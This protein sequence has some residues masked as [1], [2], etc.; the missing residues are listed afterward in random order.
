[1]GRMKTLSMDLDEMSEMHL[2]KSEIEEYLK[3]EYKLSNIT[4]KKL[5]TSYNYNHN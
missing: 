4:I 5:L 2:S 3:K 1:M